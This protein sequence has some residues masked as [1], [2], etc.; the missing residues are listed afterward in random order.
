MTDSRRVTQA[1]KE[2]TAAMTAQYRFRVKAA[3]SG[4]YFWDFVAPNDEI[5]CASQ[6]YSTKEAAI[7]GLA[8]VR[9]EGPAVKVLDHTDEPS[10]NPVAA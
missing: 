8:L 3:E 9:S 10:E 6:V 5:V 2:R 4:G 1:R 7:R